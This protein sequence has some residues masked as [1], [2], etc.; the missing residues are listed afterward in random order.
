MY[1]KNTIFCYLIF[2]SL[3]HYQ[4]FGLVGVLFGLLQTKPLLYYIWRGSKEICYNFKDKLE[5][6][7]SKRGN[8]INYFT[9]E[10]DILFHLNQLKCLD[11]SNYNRRAVEEVMES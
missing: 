1:F 7:A 9:L 5:L 11:R 6:Y 10:I 2:G 8:L 4:S 3:V